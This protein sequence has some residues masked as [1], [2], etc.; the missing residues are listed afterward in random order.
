MSTIY[1]ASNYSFDTQ[2]FCEFPAVTVPIP[3]GESFSEMRAR[4]WKSLRKFLDPKCDLLIFLW[5]P[6]EIIT[7]KIHWITRKSEPRWGSNCW[8]AKT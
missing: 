2:R 3:S 7:R 8:K 6:I 1:F 5:T 4:Q